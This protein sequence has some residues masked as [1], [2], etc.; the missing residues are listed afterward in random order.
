MAVLTSPEFYDKAALADKILSKE[1]LLE[2][3]ESKIGF[4]TLICTSECV[5][6]L[7]PLS[8]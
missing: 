8:R 7:K 5:G 1:D 6:M 3:N 2:I 4:K